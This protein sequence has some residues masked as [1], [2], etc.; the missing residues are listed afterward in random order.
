MRPAT[1]AAKRPGLAV[2]SPFDRRLRGASLLPHLSEDNLALHR[3]HRSTPSTPKPKTKITLGRWRIVTRL[4]PHCEVRVPAR[5]PCCRK[6]AG[7]GT[8]QSAAAAVAE[9][10][11]ALEQLGAALASWRLPSHTSRR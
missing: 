5:A 1:F 11:E 10:R 2:E 8:P 6:E 3:Y 7:T 9:V 4:V